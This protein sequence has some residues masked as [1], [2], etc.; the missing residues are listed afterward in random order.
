MLGFYRDGQRRDVP[1]RAHPHPDI[2]N[3][4][5]ELPV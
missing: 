1:I 5:K 2:V 3:K 4:I